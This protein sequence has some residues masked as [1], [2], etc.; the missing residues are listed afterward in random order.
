MCAELRIHTTDMSSVYCVAKVS[1]G[2]PLDYGIET[3]LRFKHDSPFSLVGC[4]DYCLVS[5]SIFQSCLQWER[6]HVAIALSTALI[7]AQCLE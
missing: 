7:R 2:E 6:T 3:E 5:C 1:V 4:E